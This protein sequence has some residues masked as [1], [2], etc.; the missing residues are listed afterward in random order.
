SD[1]ETRP[2]ASNPA[3]VDPILRFNNPGF[4]CEPVNYVF[5]LT[6]EG[7]PPYTIFY[8]IDGIAQTPWVAN[9]DT[10]YPTITADKWKKIIMIDSVK[11]ETCKGTIVGAFKFIQARD[12]V[13]STPQFIICDF[14]T[15]TYTLTTDLSGG[16]FGNFI[17]IGN[18]V[19][20]IDPS[21][22]RFVSSPLPFGQPYQFKITEAGVFSICD[23]LVL[24]GSSG[25]GVPCPSPL[26]SATANTPICSGKSL[27]LQANGGAS[28]V[29][30]GPN[31][32]T[33]DIQNPIIAQSM[34]SDAGNYIVTVTDING[35][36]ES[37]T[38]SVV[39]QASPIAQIATNSPICEATSVNLN[40][41]G[42]NT[43]SWS[44]PNGFTNSQQNL[45]ISNVSLSGGGTYT[46]TVTTTNGCTAS[47]S[48]T[49]TILT[50]PNAT[51]S[52]NSPV[53]IGNPL[54]LSATGGSTYQWAGPNGYS[55]QSNNPTIN[56]AST[57]NQGTYMV[58]VSDQNGCF[59]TLQVNVA[60]VNPSTFMVSGNSPVC[61]GDTLRLYADG[62]TTYQWVGPSQ[63]SANVQ[64]PKLPK[65]IPD[66]SG[67]YTV[68]VTA[69]GGCTGTAN[70]NIIVN[71]KTKA[72]ITGKDSICLGER[73]QLSAPSRGS[74]LWSTGQTSDTIEVSPVSKTSYFLTLSENNCTDTTLFTVNIK[75]TS[76]IQVQ[77]NL[78]ITKGISTQLFLSGA[79][80][81]VWQPSPD[82]S[83]DQCPNPIVTPEQ[84]NTYC[85]STMANGCTTDTCITIVVKEICNPAQANIFSPNNDGIND[86]WCIIALPCITTNTLRIYDRWG[87]QI[88]LQ[89]GAEICW[90]GV[91]SGNIIQ[92]QVLTYILNIEFR[93][94]SSDTKSGNFLLIK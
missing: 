1:S 19:G 64:N 14:P 20:I 62:G 44:G 21:S 18:G 73:I 33:S 56:T 90:D 29:W 31:Q 46:V 63:F 15:K 69:N 28:Y 93:D 75:P 61:E 92:D 57:N 55:S 39:V 25:C 22:K 54:Q 34:S 94:G 83:C 67:T 23:T 27:Q 12:P 53:C 87:N 72:T 24:E 82:L 30:S 60:V 17:V 50:R 32:F 51:V 66:M 43:Y 2:L 91:V 59:R 77:G 85:L 16:A 36:T 37:H 9:S 10:L 3:C 76:K 5:N 45:L 7:M 40:A 38:V 65:A 88:Y 35:C 6:F 86:Q 89:S 13:R 48:T 11:S 42:G 8:S 79:D 81:Y 47:T 4:T 41:S 71:A 58:T 26:G 74:K 70:V 68:S 49:I 52:S 80:T 84:S 78:S